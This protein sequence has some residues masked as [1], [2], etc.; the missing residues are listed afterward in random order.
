MNSLGEIIK[1]ADYAAK[2]HKDQRRKDISKSPYINHPIGV[3]EILVNAGITELEILQSAL[4]HDTIEDTDATYQEITEIF[5]KR[6]AD[7]VQE[8]S[9]DPNLDSKQQKQK[10]IDSAPG[11]SRE[12]KLVKMAD[13]IY[14]LLDL[15]KATPVG[16]SP[17]RVHEY[18]VWS[19]NVVEGILVL[20]K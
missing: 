3:A 16:W 10:Q 2:K 20:I 12:A 18:F 15:T 19:K 6:V 1:C 9:N 7:I 8:C 4:L 14:N 5:G 11:K 13:K 17:E